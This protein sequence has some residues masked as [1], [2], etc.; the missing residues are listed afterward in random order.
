MIEYEQILQT[1]KNKLRARLG[2]ICIIKVAFWTNMSSKN[3]RQLIVYIACNAVDLSLGYWLENTVQVIL[4][5]ITKQKHLEPEIG[6]M[7]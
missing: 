7:K 1:N 4:F 6:T 3:C 2:R 5:T